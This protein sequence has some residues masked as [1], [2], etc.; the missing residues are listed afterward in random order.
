MQAL[1]FVGRGTGKGYQKVRYYYEGREKESNLFPVALYEFFHP[2]RMTVFVTKESRESYWDD[3]CRQL[4]GKID[5]EPVEIPWGGK[6]DELWTIFDRVVESVEEGEEV[7]F[8]IT[9]GFRSLPFLVF[10]AVAYLR[11]V[12]NIR[13]RGVVYGALEARDSEGRASVFD[14][15][16]FLSLLDWLAAFHVFRRSGSAG[17]VSRLLRDIQ[18]QAWRQ[19]L[20]QPI[21]AASEKPKMLKRMAERINEL[22]QSLLLIRPLEVMEKAQGLANQFT[23]AALKEAEIWAKPFALI[24][25]AFREELTQFA[26]ES[27]VENLDVQRRMVSWYIDRGLYVQALTLAREL[28]VT[29]VC[30]LLD[31]LNPLRREARARAE[32]LLNYLAWDKLPEQKKQFDLWSGP[33]PGGADVE[34]FRSHPQAQS[35]IEL[36]CSIRDARNDVDHAGMNQDPSP[37]DKLARRVK[38]MGEQL[39]RLFEPKQVG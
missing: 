17:D 18:N 32:Q 15:S 29:H 16:P 20:G 3:L 4:A 8:D 2:K 26:A 6:P 25:P 1:T 28:L 10:L 35:L 24:A 12:K 13:I 14:L 7:L 11:A 23:D 30:L 9:H 21:G 39:T 37:A 33:Q 5:P 36:W 22:S 19:P 34:K 38:E 31:P 27:R